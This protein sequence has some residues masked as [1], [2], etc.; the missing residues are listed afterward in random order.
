MI[1]CGVDN[2]ALWNNQTQA[3]RLA[4]D[5]FDDQFDTSLDMDVK[6]IEL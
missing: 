1:A 2:I 4:T 5:L 6:Q 3:E